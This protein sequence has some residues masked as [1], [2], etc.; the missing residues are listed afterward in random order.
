M[1][2]LS[3]NENGEFDVSIRE[4]IRSRGLYESVREKGE[5]QPTYTSLMNASQ[6]P[7][8]TIPRRRCSPIK[9]RAQFVADILTF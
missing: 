5:G 8:Y 4:M 3:L 1:R 6:S 7:E 2:M 9:M